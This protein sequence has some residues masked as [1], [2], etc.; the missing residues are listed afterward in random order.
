MAVQ[1]WVLIPGFSRRKG[2]VPMYPKPISPVSA[3]LSWLI[4]WAGIQRYYLEGFSQTSP[5]GSDYTLKVCLRG[6]A[7]LYSSFAFH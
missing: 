6:F 7:G 1:L 4:V 5:N 2:I 3:S